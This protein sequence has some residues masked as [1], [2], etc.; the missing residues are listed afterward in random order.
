[1]IP[2]NLASHTV[3]TKLTFISIILHSGSIIR[4]IMQPFQRFISFYWTSG[5]VKI[6]ILQDL[7]IF[8]QTK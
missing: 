6:Q 3:G 5:P 1:M 2:Q 4:I 7:M 8:Y